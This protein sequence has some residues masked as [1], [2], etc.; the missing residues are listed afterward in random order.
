[1]PK[2]KSRYY[3]LVTEAIT[4]MIAS[5]IVVWFHNLFE[6]RLRFLPL[7]LLPIY[8]VFRFV[9]RLLRISENDSNDDDTQ[10]K[11]EINVSSQDNEEILT[12]DEKTRRRMATFIY[13]VKLEE[14]EYLHRKE[15]ADEIKLL[16][17]DKYT[18]QVFQRLGFS[19]EEIYQVCEC[20][21]FFV[22]NQDVLTHTETRI[23]KRSSVTQIALKNFSWNIAFQYQISGD[24]TAK[25]VVA[26]FSEWFTNTSVETVKKNLRTTTGRHAIEIDEHIVDAIE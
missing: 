2:K 17:I 15:K 16:R 13:E 8:I 22:C 14:Q 10:N 5:I 25:F 1:M 4:V 6:I 21:R 24:I 9:L 23:K 26:T 3:H 12:V 11:I 7:I 19:E 20:V 18:R